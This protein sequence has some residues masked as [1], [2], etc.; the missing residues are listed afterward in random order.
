MSRAIRPYYA[1]AGDAWADNGVADAKTTPEEI[2]ATIAAFERSG[3]DELIFT[4]NDPDPDQ[5]DQLA[6]VLSW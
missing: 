2:T 1:F 6:D 5:V 4:G 3:C